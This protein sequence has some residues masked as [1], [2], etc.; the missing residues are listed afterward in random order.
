MINS[1]YSLINGTQPKFLGMKTVFLVGLVILKQLHW[2]LMSYQFHFCFISIS[3]EVFGKN[4]KMIKKSLWSVDVLNLIKNQPCICFKRFHK[5]FRRI[6]SSEIMRP[7]AKIFSLFIPGK[8]WFS[9]S[10]L[11]FSFKPS[12]FQFCVANFS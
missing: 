3:E 10:L 6:S 9:L 11:C 2:V 7:P 4:K 12:N 1:T 8:L 5:N